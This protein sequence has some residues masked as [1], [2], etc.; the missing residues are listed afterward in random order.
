MQSSDL[1][2]FGACVSFLCLSNL[3]CYALII[4]HIWC[5]L[6]DVS[7][8]MTSSVLK[9]KSA[10]FSRFDIPK[11]AVSMTYNWR[12][13]VAPPFLGPLLL[14]GGNSVCILLLTS[15]ESAPPNTVATSTAIFLSQPDNKLSNQSSSDF[16]KATVS[17]IVC[18][19]A[20]LGLTN[21]G[22]AI[23]RH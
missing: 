11:A 13:S 12:P 10:T 14:S 22:A 16:K 7:F 23:F 4:S 18:G 20:Y 17:S 6:F 9:K 5:R 21:F 8:C 2:L 1:I 3:T 15:T 19:C